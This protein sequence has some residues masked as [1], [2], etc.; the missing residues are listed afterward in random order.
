M[1]SSPKRKS[2]GEAHSRKFQ[3]KW[4]NKFSWLEHKKKINENGEE[5]FEMY[6]RFS[7]KHNKTSVFVSGSTVVHV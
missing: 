5:I 1:A 2:F 7:V 3:S 6:C 4:I